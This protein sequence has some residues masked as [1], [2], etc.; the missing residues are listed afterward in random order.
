MKGAAGTRFAGPL[1]QGPLY[2]RIIWFHKYK[3]TEGDAD[4]IAK[5]LLDALKGVVYSDDH[6]ITHCLAARI[7]ATLDMEISQTGVGTNVFQELL[8]LLG[9]PNVRD[10]LYVEVGKHAGKGVS[11]G[12]VG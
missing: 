11:F 2:A 8:Q 4:N 12:K 1:L 6:S 3:T 7:D 10:V 9:D 5:R